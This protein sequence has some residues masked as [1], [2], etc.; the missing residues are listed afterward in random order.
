MTAE[1]LALARRV[2]E[3]GVDIQPVLGAELLLEITRLTN[4]LAAAQAK[5]VQDIGSELAKEAPAFGAVLMAICA[6]HFTDPTSMLVEA[7]EKALAKAKADQMDDYAND[8]EGHSLWDARQISQM[9]ATAAAIR[10]QAGRGGCWSRGTANI[11]AL[12]FGCAI[13]NGASLPASSTKG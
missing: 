2:I 5:A 3:M 6:D 10:K 4:A 8:M 7:L 1:R 13:A 11:V 12:A 9:R